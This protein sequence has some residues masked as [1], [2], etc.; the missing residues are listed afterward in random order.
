MKKFLLSFFAAIGIFFVI[1]ITGLVT[2]SAWR[3][4]HAHTTFPN[5]IVL[6]MVLDDA[7]P[8]TPSETDLL[9]LLG[10]EPP[11]QTLYS[12]IQTLD[13][14]RHDSRVTA[15][16][17]HLTSADA[18]LGSIQELRNA[19]LRFKRSGKKTYL[20]A[21]DLGGGPA[22]ADYWLA[23]AFDEIWVAPMGSVAPTGFAIEL[24]FVKNLLDKVGVKGEI[25]HA[26]KYKSYPE[27][28]MR[29]GAS[30]ENRD[31]TRDIL[32]H[33]NGVV[34][35]DIAA[36]RHIKPAT[37]D[38]L[39]R[40][41]PF[42]AVDALIHGLVDSIGYRD[43][44]EN[45][46]E[47]ITDGGESVPFEDYQQFGPQSPTGDKIAL[48]HVSGTLTMATAEEAM[49]NDI[50]SADAISDALAMARDDDAVR[51]IVVRVDC[52]GGTPLAADTVRRAIHLAR[53]KKP[54]VVSMGSVAAS[55]G[56]WLSTA[57]NAI[58]AQ[59]VT[60]TGS[61]GVFGG[62]L[63]LENLWKKLGVT[64]ERFYTG[65]DPSLWSL[66]T[67]YGPSAR[68][69]MDAS[70]AA[71]YDAF[72]SRVATGRNMEPDA[73]RKI[74]EGRVWTGEQGLQNGLVDV[75]GGLDVALSTAKS[76]AKIPARHNVTL[77]VLPK[78]M[79]AMEQLIHMMQSGFPTD[80]L[81]IAIQDSLT[82]TM[83]RAADHVLDASMVPTLH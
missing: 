65:A 18:P 27:T 54:V 29:A 6:S 32:G 75:V 12:R 67:P 56:Y 82:K 33:L 41:A 51:A 28:I 2:V 59:S 4:N 1:V 60:L 47:Q 42:E 61:I 40:D 49:M 31:M 72:I 7:L 39:M 26:G 25:V 19:I 36:A 23:S 17:V 9:S 70:I 24:P 8:E 57:A 58:V 34:A 74:A 52:P 15:L 80:L 53:A 46:L 76:L 71:T 45:Y 13:L 3:G 30:N 62:K 68:A 20:Y 35:A 37:I 66:N 69:K 83:T 78:P 10:H 79:G 48:V 21:D 77:D 64:W 63:Q 50:A 55:G 14:A 16:V 44:F 38:T 22:T 43:E 5:K 81:G 73:V 11:P